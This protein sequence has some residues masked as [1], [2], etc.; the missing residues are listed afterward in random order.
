MKTIRLLLISSILGIFVY[1]PAFSQEN[2]RVH[3][4][5]FKIKEDGFKEAMKSIRKGNSFYRFGRATYRS[6]REYYLKAYKYNEKNAELNYKIG[7]CYLYS[8]DKFQ[9]IKYLKKAF[10]LKPK[11]AKD[12]HFQLAR[13]YH[14]SLDFDN[15]I[16]EYN[17]YKNSVSAMKL[18]R[19][20][21]NIQKYIS[22]CET[23]KSLVSHP[24]RAIVQDLGK[25]VN[26]E[27][28]DYYPVVDSKEELMYFTSRRPTKENKNRNFFDKKFSEDIY[29]SKK[30]GKEWGTAQQLSKYLNS[31]KSE[32][33]V[34]LSPDNKYLYL[35]KS[36][37]NGSLY[38][39]QMVNGKWKSPRSLSINSRFRE[40]SMSIT[41]DGKKLYFISDRTRNSVGGKDIFYSERD[42]KGRWLSPKNI[43]PPVNTSENEEAVSISKDGKTL[44]FASKGHPSMGGYDIFSST[45]GDNGKWSKPVNI[46]YPINT[47]DDDLFFS[48]MENGK[49]AYISSVRDQ[50]IGETDLYKV[51][52]LGEEKTLVMTTKNSQPAFEIYDSVTLYRKPPEYLIVDSSIMLI[53]KVLDSETKAPIFAKMQ[54]IDSEKS[55]VVATL[56]TDTAGNYKARLPEKKTY[57]IEISAKG[58]LFFL[59]IV[60]I[61]KVKES[62]VNKDFMLQGL[63]IGAKVVMKS[64]FF[65][66]G[67]A[68]LKQ[69]SFQQLDNVI[70]FMKDNPTLKLEISGHTDNVGSVYSNTKLS[71]ARAKAVVDYMVKQGIEKTRL[72]FKGYG[73]TQPVAPNTTKDGKAKNRRVEFKITAK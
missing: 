9:A 6:A 28:D 71:E 45:L 25:S 10:E 49:V 33:A 52:F 48:M 67:K 23:G 40:T 8:D 44:Y 17:Q 62:V 7:I 2:V 63:E 5:E 70:G 53:G 64:I 43:G 14:M 69:A 15:A 59:D 66:T 18:E 32:A 3:R 54:F 51:I 11:V 12:I 31:S 38:S 58:Y 47:P 50:G 42:A 13:A 26:S 22:E 65:E 39:T 24:V 36:S 19:L 60:D 4:K 27:Y 20:N 55:A 73:P 56:L 61:S 57:G 29:V 16:K 46:G 34:A 30:K 41:S 1:Q 21:I 35:F 72:T 37:G 68:T